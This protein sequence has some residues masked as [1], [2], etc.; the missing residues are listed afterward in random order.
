M[1]DQ[2]PIDNYYLQ[3]PEEYTDGA[4]GEEEVEWIDDD[5]KI[6]IKHVE[7]YISEAKKKDTPYRKVIFQIVLWLFMY[8]FNR[9]VLNKIFTGAPQIIFLEIVFVTTFFLMVSYLL[10]LI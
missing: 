9:L 7:D 2:R 6:R 5:T 1:I 3:S 10:D 8:S 4:E